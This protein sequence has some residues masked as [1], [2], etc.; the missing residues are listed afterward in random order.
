[1]CFCKEKLKKCWEISGELQGSF[2]TLS[3]GQTNSIATVNFDGA[4]SED[5]LY[6]KN[7]FNATTLNVI[8]SSD[9][10]FST[11]SGADAPIEVNAT[12]IVVDTNSILDFTNVLTTISSTL[13]IDNASSVTVYSGSEMTVGSTTVSGA[14]SLSLYDSIFTGDIEIISAADLGEYDDTNS[15]LSLSNSSIEGDILIT[16]GTLIISDDVTIVGTIKGSTSGNS[17]LTLEA[18]DYTLSTDIGDDVGG[19]FT[20]MTIYNNIDTGG[21]SLYVTDIAL[22]GGSQFTAEDGTLVVGNISASSATQGDVIV[23][24]AATVSF[25]EIGYDSIGD[26]YSVNSVLTGANS[27]VTFAG[28]LNMANDF[29]INGEAIFSQTST[30]ITAANFNLNSG[31]ILHLTIAAG[32]TA[33]AIDLVGIANIDANTTLKLEIS[34][35]FAL[36]DSV[37][38]VDASESSTIAAIIDANIKIKSGSTFVNNA[39]G[40]ALFSTRI[41]G[42]S[43]ILYASFI[44]ASTTNFEKPNNQNTYNAINGVNSPTGGLAIVQ[45]YLASSSN[46]IAQKEEVLNSLIPAVDRGSNAAI[47]NNS[48][49]LL[50]LN[51]ARLS[52][53]GASASIV[54]SSFINNLFGSQTRIQ[55]LEPLRD[56]NIKTA[57]P[58]SMAFKGDDN[59]GKAM[60][61]QTFGSNIS[62]NN[63]SSGDGYK[64]NSGGVAI[65]I[66]QK[67][68]NNFTLG[69]SSSYSQSRVKS[70]VASKSTLINTYQASIY[71]G[72]NAKSYFLNSSLGL[73]LNNYS[74]N[75][76]IDIVGTTAKG[77]YSGRSY[78]ARVELGKNFKF[79]NDLTITPSVTLTGAHNV[80]NSYTETGA[81]SLNLHVKNNSSNFFE[82]RIGVELGKLFVTAKKTKIRPQSSLSYGYDFAGIEQKTTS[83]FVGQTASFDSKSA[84]VAQ[85]SLKFGAGVGFYTKNDITFSTTYGLEKRIDYTAHSGWLR[86]RLGF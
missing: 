57:A 68:S 54:E 33:P 75:R 34:G 16:S 18:A 11:A 86:V 77:D 26:S 73:S 50:N 40:N 59:L 17:Y 28:N 62:Q 35:T 70:N 67:L 72:Y 1:V 69:L 2:I 44:D 27:V 85:G 45:D 29:G 78:F 31:S 84:N 36:N 43:L 71:T 7:S 41:E 66:D 19:A 74:S 4:G 47:N 42:D 61:I 32:Q 13:T 9:S 80:I 76:N 30:T 8:N 79:K 48:S 24:S 5:G 53:S 10:D 15:S 56:N 52:D 25:Q 55:T 46:T 60:W 83:N 51:S 37:I 65:G 38:L 49:N 63:T 81:D 6:F 12:T 23:S 14:G 64:A 3:I 21:K 82:G 20:K 22:T 58:L 39:Y